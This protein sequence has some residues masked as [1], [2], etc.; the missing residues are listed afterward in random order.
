AINSGS[1][2]TLKTDKA[3]DTSYWKTITNASSLISVKQAEAYA[4]EIYDALSFVKG[5]PSTDSVVVDT[6]K[7]LK[8]KAQLSQVGYHYNSLYNRSLYEDFN[9]IDKVTVANFFINSVYMPDRIELSNYIK[10]L[11]NS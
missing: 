11:P 10:S 7:K 1:D 2:I 8:N 6:I 3:F 4:K 9:Y 5:I